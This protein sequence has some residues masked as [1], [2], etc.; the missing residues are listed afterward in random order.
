M[1]GKASF[2]M[3]SRFLFCKFSWFSAND[4][5]PNIMKDT[6]LIEGSDDYKDNGSNNEADE[7]DYLKTDENG[8]QG[9]KRVEPDA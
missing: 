3:N 5:I 9:Y 4:E 7:T 6:E 2:A 1:A 8:N